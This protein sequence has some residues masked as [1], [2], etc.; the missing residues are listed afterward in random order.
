M[1]PRFI[2]SLVDGKDG[3]AWLLYDLQR[4]CIVET[5]CDYAD[6]MVSKAQLSRLTVEQ[7]MGHLRVFWAFLDGERIDVNDISDQKL[8]TFRDHALKQARESP[9]H[10]GSEEAAKTTVNAKLVRIYDWLIWLQE[11][12]RVRAN[13]IGARDCRVKSALETSAVSLLR[14]RDPALGSTARYPLLFRLKASRSKHRLA[15]FVP[16]EETLDTVHAYFLGQIK[17]EHAAHRN[18][19]IADVASYI[20]FRRASIQSLTTMQFVGVP[21]VDFVKTDHSTVL[22]QPARQK[23]DYGDTYEL[24]LWLHDAVGTFIEQYRNPHI[25]K[26]GVGREIHKDKVFISDRDGRPLTDRAISALM[27]KAM[28]AAGAPKGTSMHAWRSKYAVEETAEV[29]ERRR[30]LG[31]DTSIGTMDAVVARS[32]GHKNPMSA[33][34]YTSAYE[35]AEVARRRAQR[36][37]ERH[38]EKLRIRELEAE[39]NMLRQQQGR[40]TSS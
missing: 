37:S 18:C 21:K 23:F 27:S 5:L 33:R 32:L 22:I 14:W 26:L 25:D 16:T 17:S 12:G 31:L 1:T 2:S 10:R 3:I 24:P 35:A 13:L 34:A 6:D 9:S 4:K 40:D 15:K 7:E 19:M 20:G 28:R 8:V 11:S 38:A 39:N 36:E 30:E 29:Y